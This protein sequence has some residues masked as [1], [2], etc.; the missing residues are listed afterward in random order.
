VAA[1]TGLRYGILKTRQERGFD[2]RVGWYE[3]TIAALG[4]LQRALGDA[5]ELEKEITCLPEDD[6]ARPGTAQLLADVTSVWQR[7][8]SSRDA[9]A[10]VLPRYTI[11]ADSWVESECAALRALLGTDMRWMFLRDELGLRR[12]G[13]G[14]RRDP[15]ASEH[16]VAYEVI[17]WL[18]HVEAAS[19]T[20][21]ASIRGE[22]GYART[23]SRWRELR[24]RIWRRIWHRIWGRWR[25]RSVRQRIEAQLK[26]RHLLATETPKGHR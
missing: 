8:R 6:S 18:T 13:G 26:R 14:S 22:L 10:R 1:R 3:E 16:E 15:A 2:R 11:Y 7:V 9:L 23:P 4:D 24:L 12:A 17:N 19:R 25:A 5:L 20:L 21:V